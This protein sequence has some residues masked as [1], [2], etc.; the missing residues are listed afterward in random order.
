M[1]MAR[2]WFQDQPLADN[3]WTRR[4]AELRRVSGMSLQDLKR[5]MGYSLASAQRA[6]G[7]LTRVRHGGR[8]RPT[9]IAAL[10]RVEEAHADDYKAAADGRIFWYGKRRI[11]TRQTSRPQDLK[12]LDQPVGMAN[13]R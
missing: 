9:F 13:R 1:G 4:I 6:K 8:P 11:D 3:L 5:E 7:A 2:R 10:K 12:D